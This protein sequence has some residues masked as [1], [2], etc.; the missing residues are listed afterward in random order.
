VEAYVSYRIDQFLEDPKRFV[1]A[2]PVPAPPGM[3][4]GDDG[5]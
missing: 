2:T 4:I 1:V 5:E 3:P